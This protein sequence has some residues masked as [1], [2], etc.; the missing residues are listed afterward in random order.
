ML[1]AGGL[2]LFGVAVY[3][4]GAVE[5]AGTFEESA[6]RLERGID[7]A[8]E[9]GNYERVQ[10]L[11]LELAERCAAAQRYAEAARQYE[12]LLASRPSRR[13]RVEMFIQ[14]GKMR[15]ALQDFGGAISAF[16]DAL[17]DNPHSWEARLALARAYARVELNSRAL[18]EYGKCIDL[19]PKAPEP[20]EEMAA[21]YQRL[22]YYGKAIAFYQKALRLRARPE[23]FLG[24]AD[25]YAHQDN[26]SQ[27][28]NVLQQAKAVLP[29][30]DYDV[31][32][33]SIYRDRGDLMHAVGA[34]EEALKTDASRDDVRLNLAL[35]YGELRRFR[36]AEAMYR[37]L[38]K[39]YPQS[40]LVHFL[41]AWTLYDRADYRAAKSEALAVKGLSPSEVVRHYDERLLN[42]LRKMS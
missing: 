37:P 4:L 24:M 15:V 6:S 23:S 9:Q 22:S 20:Y 42:E 18:G 31:R 29:R 33:G 36:D 26:F 38:L 39:R 27:A 12:L 41:H 25:C 5:V 11:R 10:T 19:H 7:Q 30:A 35:A 34:W 2:G 3:P 13:Q 17:H 40:P 16:Q 1:L 21:V 8:S 32:L 14:L 28:T